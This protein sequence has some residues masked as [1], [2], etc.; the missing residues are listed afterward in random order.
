L[1]G[2]NYQIFQITKFLF[3]KRRKRRGILDGIHK[4]KGMGKTGF[5]QDEQEGWT[6]EPQKNAKNAKNEAGG[7]GRMQSSW[8]F[9]SYFPL[10][11]LCVLSAK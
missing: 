1:E 11:D 4:I 8:R 6:V 2:P 5:R 7:A 3:G 9:K 10:Q